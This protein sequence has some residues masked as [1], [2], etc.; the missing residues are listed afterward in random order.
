[1]FYKVYPMNKGKQLFILF[2][3][4]IACYKN[5]NN[6]LIIDYYITSLNVS[7]NKILKTSMRVF[8]ITFKFTAKFAEI[9][10]SYSFDWIEFFII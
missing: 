9:N 3:K 4:S 6:L 1:M 10:I 2:A 5:I 8:P 7:L